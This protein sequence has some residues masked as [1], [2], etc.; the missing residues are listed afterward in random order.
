MKYNKVG[1]SIISLGDVMLLWELDNLTDFHRA[2]SN[3][4]QFV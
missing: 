3:N 2:N 4:L 1:L